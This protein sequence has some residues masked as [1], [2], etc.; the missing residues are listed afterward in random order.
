MIKN[1]IRSVGK[2]LGRSLQ[3]KNKYTFYNEVPKFDPSKDYYSILNVTKD[4]SE[5][6]IK[7]SYYAL[8]KKYHPDSNPGL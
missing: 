8:A 5:S 7:R 1:L 3:N 2:T 6:D 4:S